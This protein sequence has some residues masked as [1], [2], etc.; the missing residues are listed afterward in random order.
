MKLGVISNNLLHFETA[1]E[2]LQYARDLGFNAVEVGA[3]GLWNKRFCDPEMLIKDPGEVRR[4]QDRFAEKE[5]EVK[6]F[7]WSRRATDAR[8]AGGR[9]VF[10]RV[11]HDLR[12]HGNGRRQAYYADGWAAGRG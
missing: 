12:V 7:G 2:G 10:A 6:C 5:L 3:L 11:S 8:Q 9:A 1:E 4:W